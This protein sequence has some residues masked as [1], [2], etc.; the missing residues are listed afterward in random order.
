[1]EL[2]GKIFGSTH[3]V[4]IMRLFLSNPTDPFEL[5]DI[6]KRSRVKKP[7]A[8]K[9][10]A[11]LVKIGFIKKK[12]FTVEVPQR[13]TKKRPEVTY[14]KVKRNGFVL[15]TR[16]RLLKQL[17]LLLLDSSSIKEK[18]IAARIKKT[19]SIK[20]L[21][22]SG[23]FVNDVDQSLDILVVGKNIKRDTL[24]RE[25]TI[26]ESEVGRELSYTFFDEDEFHYRL[27]MYDKLIRDILENPH[28]KLVNTLLE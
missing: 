7:N 15:N 24:E 13:V 23:W 6:A 12:V 21:I 1:M 14:K 8:R 17:Q 25:I 4:K 10:I 22:L 5:E 2:L 11:L 19:G 27:S 20:L 18:D 16:F 3:R 26:I 9:E 28:K